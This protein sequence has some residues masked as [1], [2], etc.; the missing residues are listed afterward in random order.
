MA[1]ALVICSFLILLFLLLKFITPEISRP[2]NDESNYF[3]KTHCTLK[4]CTVEYVK[5]VL[6]Q[7]TQSL[8]HLIRLTDKQ[9]GNQTAIRT[10]AN[11]NNNNHSRSQQL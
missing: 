3:S 8:F 2:C 10:I 9:R 7:N 1:L 4:Q 11:S 6:K 5:Y